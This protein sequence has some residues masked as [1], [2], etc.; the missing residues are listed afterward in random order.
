MPLHMQHAQDWQPHRWQATVSTC[1]MCSSC[2]YDAG[3]VVCPCNDL[4]HNQPELAS[5]K[6]VT[7]DKGPEAV[8]A[9][10]GTKAA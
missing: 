3:R 6:E 4:A 10:S 8:S 5:D 2:L 9:S 1:C 7:G